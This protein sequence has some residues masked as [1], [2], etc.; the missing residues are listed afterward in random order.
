MKASD[1]TEHDYIDVDILLE[2]YIEQ[3]QIRKKQI[4]KDLQKEFMKKFTERRD[5]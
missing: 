5:G 3:Y 1:E 2:M 4:L